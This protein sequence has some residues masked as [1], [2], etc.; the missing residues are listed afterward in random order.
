MRLAFELESC[1]ATGTD[2]I[3]DSRVGIRHTKSC[4]VAGRAV[5]VEAPPRLGNYP[6]PLARALV[7][8]GQINWHLELHARRSCAPLLSLPPTR[9]LTLVRLDLVPTR[10]A[11]VIAHATPHHDPLRAVVRAFVIVNVLSFLQ[12]HRAPNPESRFTHNR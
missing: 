6:A 12:I 9:L 1:C 3:D 7:S 11:T 5:E 8:R 10:W 2:E 4:G